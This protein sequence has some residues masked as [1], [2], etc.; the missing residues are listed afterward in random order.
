WQ[1]EGCT[2]CGACV[3]AC[4]GGFRKIAGTAW[5]AED[6]AARLNKAPTCSAPPAAA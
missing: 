1:P 4:R 3:P 5:T 6:L 2:A